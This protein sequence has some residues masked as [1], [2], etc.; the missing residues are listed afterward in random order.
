MKSSIARIFLTCAVVGLTCAFAAGDTL[1]T[2]DGKTF[3]GRIIERSN[4]KVVFE[5]RQY[6]AKMVKTFAKSEIQSLREGPTE[7]PSDKTGPKTGDPEP[8]APPVVQ[9][10][11][12]TYYLIPMTGEIGT[13]VL[14]EY[15][16]RSLADAALRR[17]D[18][19]VLVIDS[20]GGL[21]SEANKLIQ[22]IQDNK[23][24][25]R[26][27]A[28]VHKALSA[29]AIT[30]LACREIYVRPGAIIGAATAY[31]KT[32][33]GFPKAISEKMQS[34]WRAQ[35]RSAAE[36]GGHNPLLAEA[37]I[38]LSVSLHI[39]KDKDGKVRVLRG[40]GGKMLT[41]KGKLLTLTAGEA[42]EAG[43][44]NGSAEDFDALGQKL[45]LDGWVECKGHAMLLAE[46][47]KKALKQYLQRTGELSKRYTEHMA[48]AVENSPHRPKIPYRYDPRTGKYSGESQKRWYKRSVACVTWLRKAEQDLAQTVKLTEQMEQLKPLTASLR[49]QMAEIKK[50]RI[51]IARDMHKKGPG[52]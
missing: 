25:L 17:P 11:Q 42:T 3:Q 14:S 39:V 43:L 19:V 20:P 13:Y 30:S 1:V 36:M 38:D 51:K 28:Y 24:K 41:T 2:K 48:K 4:G 8:K 18:V 26:I 10:K 50:L 6:G 7:V 15:L 31:R 29:A 46:H 32:P 23:K 35:A 45:G 47:W 40:T 27:V 33:F 34:V 22:L 5:I 49:T 21:T 16:Q 44:A 37:M 12:K 52:I 9:Y